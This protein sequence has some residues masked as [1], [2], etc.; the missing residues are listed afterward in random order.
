VQNTKEMGTKGR[1]M[2]VWIRTLGS[3]PYL[4]SHVSGSQSGATL[5]AHTARSVHPGTDKRAQVLLISRHWTA[6]WWCSSA[7]TE[8]PRIPN[9]RRPIGSGNVVMIALGPAIPA[10]Q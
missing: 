8:S 1:R 10:E 4:T 9:V 2:G 5:C 3:T 6:K 7:E